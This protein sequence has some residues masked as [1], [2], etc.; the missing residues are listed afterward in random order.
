MQLVNGARFLN[1]NFL[2]VL[3]AIAP[4]AALLLTDISP[5]TN[6]YASL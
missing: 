5:L 3:L 6:I 2:L 4:A 1:I